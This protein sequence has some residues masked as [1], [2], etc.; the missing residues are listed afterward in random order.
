VHLVGFYY[1][2]MRKFDIAVMRIIL[3]SRRR[4]KRNFKI[5]KMISK[6]YGFF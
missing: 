6:S 5:T 2:K 1:K 3:G 4:A